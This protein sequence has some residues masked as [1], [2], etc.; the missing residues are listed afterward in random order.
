MKITMEDIM[1][2]SALE[3]VTGVT[4]K[5]CMVEGQLVS[6]LVPE[7]MVGKAIGKAAVNVKMLEQKLGKRIEIVAYSEKP[8]EIFSKALEVTLNNSK[9]N[10]SRLIV[11]LDGENKAKAFKNNSRIKRVKEL[12]KRNFNLDLVI[13]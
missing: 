12:I 2:R 1:M 6:Y 3:K 4:P 11:N 10:G 7:S 9:I 13:N 8:E 5:D